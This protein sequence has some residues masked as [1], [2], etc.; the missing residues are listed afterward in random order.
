[1]VYLPTFII[2]INQMYVN[3]PYMDGMRYCMML[4][5]VL[6]GWLAN[7]AYQ[8]HGKVFLVTASNSEASIVVNGRVQCTFIAPTVQLHAIN[9]ICLLLGG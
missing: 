3:I 4:L 9:K 2:K 5:E 7:P 6:W 1:M 8:D